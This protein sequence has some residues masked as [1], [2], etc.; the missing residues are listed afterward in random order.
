MKC[1]EEVLQAVK[2]ITRQ[3]RSETFTPKEVITY[4]TIK[5]SRYADSTIRTHIVSRCCSNAP[6]NFGTTYNYFVRVG[7]GL[8]SIR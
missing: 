8:Y 1:H 4:M 5:G 3:K 7:N 6:I 2:E